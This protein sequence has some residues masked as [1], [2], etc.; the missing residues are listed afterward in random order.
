MKMNAFSISILSLTCVVFSGCNSAGAK[1]FFDEFL[2]GLSGN[3]LAYNQ[4]QAYYSSPQQCTSWSGLKVATIAPS[5]STSIEARNVRARLGMVETDVSRADAL[6]VV[7]RSALL[8][9]LNYT[10]N[11]LAELNRDAEYQLNICGTNFHVYLYEIQSY[12]SIIQV[13]HT[14]YKASY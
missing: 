6:L 12:S 7:V 13:K 14:S 3:A 4:Q 11:S 2:A 9:P 1:E 10:Y 8:N 5:V